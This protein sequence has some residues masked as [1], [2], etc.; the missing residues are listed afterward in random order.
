MGPVKE[1][2]SPAET[3]DTAELDYFFDI[4]E[5]FKSRLDSKDH[6][7]ETRELRLVARSPESA[8]ARAILKKC[9]DLSEKGITLK[10]IFAHLSPMPL[11]SEWISPETSPC[12]MEATNL[13][14]WA[15]RPN[16]VDAH[17]QFTLDK[18]CSWS[19]ESMRRDV[20]ARFGF[21]LFDENCQHTAKL[22]HR[23]FESLWNVADAIPQAQIKRAR[24]VADSDLTQLKAD[25]AGITLHSTQLSSPE[26]T[27]H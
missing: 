14:R 13:I 2:S 16:L 12:G 9:S 24:L 10:V 19:G 22:A 15:N 25:A 23:S 7:Q 21:Y 17:E 5:Q 20:N 8:I 3:D 27:R 11:F 1:I 26:F 18:E 6:E 4:L